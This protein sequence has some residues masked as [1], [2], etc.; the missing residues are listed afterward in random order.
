MGAYRTPLYA[1]SYYEYNRRKT[2]KRRQ[3]GESRFLYDTVDL[4]P[5]LAKAVE[6]NQKRR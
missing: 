4:T 3:T 6:A 2:D 1:P 5:E